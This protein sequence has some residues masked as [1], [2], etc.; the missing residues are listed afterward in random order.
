M[1]ILN[2]LLS[3]HKILSSLCLFLVVTVIPTIG[4]FNLTSAYREERKK[5]FAKMLKNARESDS[6][7]TISEI[8]KMVQE[9]QDVL[10][11]LTDKEAAPNLSA[12][13]ISVRDDLLVSGEETLTHIDEA[14]MRLKILI[15]KLAD[16]KTYDELSD[17]LHHFK[18]TVLHNASVLKL[19]DLGAGIK[20]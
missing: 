7:E 2:T 15:N 17:N 6:L 20:K 14:S 12:D 1:I 18:G 11:G 5:W 4:E 9:F 10:I 3:E 8:R 16:C 19:L 13:E